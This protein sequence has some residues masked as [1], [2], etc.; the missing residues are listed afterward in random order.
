MKYTNQQMG[1]GTE[2][3]SNEE[4]QM[5]HKYM[6]KRSTSLAIREKQI[7]ITLRFHLTQ[8]RMAITKKTVTDTG[9]NG[10]GGRRNRG[11]VIPCLWEYK[12][13]QPVWKSVLMLL[14]RL[15][16]ELSY[17]LTIPLLDMYSKELRFLQRYLYTC[18]YRNTMPAG[19]TLE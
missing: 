7:K 14:I 3:F 5:V 4:V 12:L 18:V 6:K 8:G 10:E 2:H 17:G 15:K 11:H 1:N 16:I 9:Q 13:V 19:K